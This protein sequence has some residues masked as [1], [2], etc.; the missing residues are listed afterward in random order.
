MLEDTAKMGREE[1]AAR[2]LEQQTMGPDGSL[3][4]V[5]L[6]FLAGLS[7]GKLGLSYYAQTG[8]VLNSEICL[9]KV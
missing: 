5:C 6:I 7:S 1:K 9:R 8:E 4:P 3:E 2:A